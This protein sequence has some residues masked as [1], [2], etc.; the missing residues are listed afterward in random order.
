MIVV[1]IDGGP[2]GNEALRFALH[3]ATLRGTRVRAVHAWSVAPVVPMTGPGFIETYD[4]EPAHR[5]ATATLNEVLEAVA[6]DRADQIERVVVQGGAGEAIIENAHDAELIVVGSHQHGAIG[7]LVLG[8]VSQ[9]VVK[10]ATC[11]VA[12]VPPVPA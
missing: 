10:H 4:P 8:S 12:V 9:H 2:L 11:P 3:E 7:G 6:G 1:G 5:A